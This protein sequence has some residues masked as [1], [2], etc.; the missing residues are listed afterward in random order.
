MQPAGHYPAICELSGILRER[1]KHALGD[2]L[3]E[4]GIA[5]HAQRGGIN[6]IHVAAHQFGKGRFRAFFGV[7]A[8]QL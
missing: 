3:G 1:N 2:I 6:E 5:N 7:S 4:M 8:Q